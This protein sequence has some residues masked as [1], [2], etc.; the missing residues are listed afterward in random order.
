MD[1]EWFFEVINIASNNKWSAAVLLKL[2]AAAFNCKVCELQYAARFYTSKNNLLHLHVIQFYSLSCWFADCCHNFE[3][4]QFA[5]KCCH[6][7]TM[8]L[9]VLCCECD[10]SMSSVSILSSYIGL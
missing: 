6:P 9:K 4:C 8:L 10:F 5:Q 2:T 1:S 3:E 7:A